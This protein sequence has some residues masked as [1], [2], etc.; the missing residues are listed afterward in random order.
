MI[1]ETA[2]DV[3][4]IAPMTAHLNGKISH[5]NE[6]GLAV[7]GWAAIRSAVTAIASYPHPFIF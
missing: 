3:V 1:S 4:I 6:Q 2:M 5:L 7:S